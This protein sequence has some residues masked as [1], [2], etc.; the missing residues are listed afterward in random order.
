MLTLLFMA[1]QVAT[2]LSANLDI[3][4][5]QHKCLLFTFVDSFLSK[6][7]AKFFEY[8]ASL[9]I[10]KGVFFLFELD[11]FKFV[12]ESLIAFSS[13]SATKRVFEISVVITPDF[14]EFEK[15]SMERVKAIYPSI[16]TSK[17]T[18]TVQLGIQFSLRLSSRL[19]IFIFKLFNRKK[20]L[21]IL[22]LA[23]LV[24][25]QPLVFCPNPFNINFSGNKIALNEG[26]V[27]IL[28]AKELIDLLL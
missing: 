25:E 11:S 7:E 5:L 24:N 3:K 23:S 1:Y 22:D 21:E 14:K 28:D 13:F 20:A 2:F 9:M 16:K 18:N 6:E 10:K 17:T 19:F 4:E 27:L 12:C 26:S 8:L 15:I